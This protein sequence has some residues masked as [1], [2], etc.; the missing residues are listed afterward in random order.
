MSRQLLLAIGAMV[1]AVAAGLAWSAVRTEREFRR[2]LVEGDTALAAGQTLD[3]VEAFSGALALRPDS[4]VAHLKRGESYRLRGELEPALRD[5]RDAAALDPAAPQPV[6][7]LGDV[8]A[9]MGRWERAIELYTRFI[10]LDERE[11]RVHYKLGLALYRAGRTAQA[12]DAAQRALAIDDAFAEAHYLRGLCLRDERRPQ[13]AIQMLRRAITLKP[14]LAPAREALADLYRVAGRRRDQIEQLEALAALEPARPE[15]VVSIATAYA[16]AGRVDA[17]LGTLERIGD[18]LPEDDP[19]RVE[20]AR[21]WLSAAELRGEPALVRSARDL[22]EPVATRS[23][24]SGEALAVWGQS[25]LLLGDAAGAERTLQ[26]AVAR[27]PVSPVAFRALADAAER[28]GHLTSARSALVDYAT[29]VDADDERQRV[30]GRI[31]T[32]SLALK[33]APGASRWAEQALG[34]SGTSGATAT[35]GTAGVA[36]TLA[37]ARLALGDRAGAREAVTRGLALEPRQRD[38]IRLQRQLG[39]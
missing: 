33:D 32:L 11:A 9:A 4:M 10:A 38:L 21:A 15:R 12:G 35:Q 1:L 36:L 17:A 16:R 29:L 25:Q 23:D 30:A 8:N 20:V 27:V 3:A 6:E 22:V 31:A 28:Q 39:R 26:R 7:R 37:R 34:G 18:R 19:L 13:D 14:D 2:L 5:L 24:A